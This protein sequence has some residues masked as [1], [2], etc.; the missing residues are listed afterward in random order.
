MLIAAWTIW[1][2]RN[3]YTHGQKVRTPQQVATWIYSYYEDIKNSQVLNEKDTQKEVPHDP[4]SEQN[5]G[6]ELTMFVDVVI[7]TP[8]NMVGFGVVI[9]AK[10]RNVKAALSKPLQGDKF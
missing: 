5:E 10:E 6:S 9:F 4:R 8:T 7:S 2:E 3:K 1:Y